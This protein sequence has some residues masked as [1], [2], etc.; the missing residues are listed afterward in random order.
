MLYYKHV[1]KL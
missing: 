1:I